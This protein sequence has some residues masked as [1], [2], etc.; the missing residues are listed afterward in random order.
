[1]EVSVE[2]AYGEVS[3]GDILAVGI[4][5]ALLLL[6]FDENRRWKFSSI[7]LMYRLTIPVSLQMVMTSGDY[8]MSLT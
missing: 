3:V 7:A 5:V 4:T 8:G 6:C 2:V 1:M